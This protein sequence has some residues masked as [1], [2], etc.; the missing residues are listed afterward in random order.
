MG[1]PAT[2]VDVGTRVALAPMVLGEGHAGLGWPEGTHEL[3]GPVV[4]CGPEMQVMVVS[5][6]LSHG[7][8]GTWSW[9]GIFLP[10]WLMDTVAVR[11]CP[12]PL[13]SHS[14]SSPWW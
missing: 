11:R 12:P 7:T 1:T 14:Y 8:P 6:L 9:F 5:K 2:A 10:S 4:F 3:T 13:P